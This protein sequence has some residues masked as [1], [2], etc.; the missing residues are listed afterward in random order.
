MIPGPIPQAPQRSWVHMAPRKSGY[1]AGNL[2]VILLAPDLSA[3][4]LSVRNQSA[5]LSATDLAATKSVDLAFRKY[6]A[7]SSR[8]YS[9]SSNN[10]VSYTKSQEGEL[11]ETDYLKKAY[12]YGELSGA[13]I[14]FFIYHSGRWFTY[15]STDRQSFPS[16]EQIVSVV[17]EYIHDADKKTANVISTAG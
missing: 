6:K 10:Y 5:I 8:I 2:S 14:A 17:T 7:P 1:S 16:W 4:N 12:E 3:T 11:S 13:D 9:L 15:R